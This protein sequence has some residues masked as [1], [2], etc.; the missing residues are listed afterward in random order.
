[1]RHRALVGIAVLAL[2]F[3]GGGREGHASGVLG[4]ATGADVALELLW[5]ASGEQTCEGAPGAARPGAE[6][7]EALW[8]SAVQVRERLA[9]G[10]PVSLVDVRGTEAF[11]AA[12][13]PGTLSVPLFA[14]KTMGFLRHR[15]VVLVGEDYGLSG[16]AAEAAA[17]GKAGFSSVR[18][19][20]GGIGQW[21]RAGGG[22]EGEALEALAVPRISPAAYVA[23]GGRRDW[24][25]VLVSPLDGGSPPAGAEKLAEAL[26]VAGAEDLVREVQGVLDK[27]GAGELVSVVVATPQ[28]EGYGPLA[29]ALEGRVSPGGADWNVY[30]LEG[31][32]EGYRR[33]AEALK[34][35]HSGASRVVAGGGT[36]AGAARGG[37]GSCR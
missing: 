26:R 2:G 27:R 29:A 8:I 37:C 24:V 17:L 12:R 4:G 23:E 22:L 20:R 11:A 7:E 6:E 33:Y 14:V 10:G 1:M 3:A 18:I 16:L 35:R 9:Q 13:I 19:L 15:E 31:G 21:R 5:P 28:G 32:T 25:T 30:F 36:P 34:R